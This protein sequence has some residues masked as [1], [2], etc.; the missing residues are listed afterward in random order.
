M[1]R[2]YAYGRRFLSWFVATFTCVILAS[3]VFIGIHS[4]PYLPFRL[5]AQAAFI[6][7]TSSL[8]NF[9]LVSEKPLRRRRMAI[10]TAAHFALLLAMAS[11]CAWR[12]E[13]FS[14]GHAPSALLFTLLFIAVYAVIWTTSYVGDLMNERRIN[15]AL[16]AY[17]QR[18]APSPDG[19]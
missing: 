17:R 13:W 15:G 9:L 12:F 10:R 18:H 8:A 6:S 2:F 14:F 7:A 4:N 1:E 3:T 19:P 11:L 5:V 16:K